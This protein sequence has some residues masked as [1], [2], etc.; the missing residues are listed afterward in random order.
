[1]AAAAEQVEIFGEH[2]GNGIAS[3][4]AGNQCSAHYG[5]RSN[6]N[7][8]VGAIQ[9]ANNATAGFHHYSSGASHAPKRRASDTP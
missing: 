8:G 5:I 7:P 6:S 4:N 2:A 1:M 3:G 9:H